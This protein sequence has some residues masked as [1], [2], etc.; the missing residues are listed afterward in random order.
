MKKGE[1]PNIA[2]IG[3]NRSAANEHPSKQLDITF[4]QSDIPDSVDADVKVTD[5]RPLGFFVGLNNTGDR[6]TGNWRATLGAQHTNLWNL[7]H[8]VTATYTTSP[9]RPAM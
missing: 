3:R 1:S 5:E 4:R 8:S 7:D 2:A 6:R 9:E